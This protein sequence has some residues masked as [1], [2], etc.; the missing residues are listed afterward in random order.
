MICSAYVNAIGKVYAHN[1]LFSG[2][3]FLIYI[4]NGYIFLKLM[5]ALLDLLAKKSLF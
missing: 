1:K 2:I 3:L 5:K 4:V